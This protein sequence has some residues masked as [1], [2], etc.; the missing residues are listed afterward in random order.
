[1]FICVRN[2][3]ACTELQVDEDFAI[4][5][6][7]VKG[8]DPKYAWQII[9]TYRAPCEDTR[10]IVRLAAR[11][12]YSRN[13][14]KRNIIVGD[15]NLPQADRN[16]R[17]EATSGNKAFINRLLWENGYTQVVLVGTEASRSRF[18]PGNR[19]P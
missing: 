18:E 12:G 6:V 3:N 14:T 8:M 11:T 2:Y 10:V 7:A 13:S 16:G 4:I 19:L 1:V 17:A 15:L 5:A 9:G